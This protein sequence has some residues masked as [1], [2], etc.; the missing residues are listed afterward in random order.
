MQVRRTT[1]ISPTSSKFGTIRPHTADLAALERLKNIIFDWI[2][3]ILAGNKDNYVVSNEFEI[4][5]DP[6]MDCGVRCS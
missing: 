4:R 6:N 2:F 1:I 3:F 5:P